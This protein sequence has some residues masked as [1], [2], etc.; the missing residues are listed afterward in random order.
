MPGWMK[1]GERAYRATVQKPAGDCYRLT[2]EGTLEGQ[3]EWEW[4][5]WTSGWSRQGSCQS[6]IEAMKA[7][8][9]AIDKTSDLA[10]MPK[11]RR[12]AAWARGSRP[13]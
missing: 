9:S 8:E 10:S 2:V 1:A 4:V 6:V 12:S 7:A 11:E 5:A 3:A 13:H